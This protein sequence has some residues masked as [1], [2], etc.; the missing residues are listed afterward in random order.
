MAISY[1]QVASAAESIKAEGGKPTLAAIHA[2]LGSGSMSTITKFMQRW[3]GEQPQQQASEG[4]IL[5]EQMKTA[6]IQEME[7]YA[8]QRV[9]MVRDE[10]DEAQRVIGSL[11]EEADGLQCQCEAYEEQ[12]DQGQSLIVS[13]DAKIKKLE[14]DTERY[15]NDRLELR[16]RS[17]ELTLKLAAAQASNELLEREVVEMKKTQ[18]ALQ[19]ALMDAKAAISRLEAQKEGLTERVGELKDEVKELKNQTVKD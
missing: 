2:R 1:E 15:L 8:S 12:L 9:A 6:I 3:K 10:L 16:E 7:R 5:P 13:Q 14:A 4:L 11:T 19:S 17:D 18:S